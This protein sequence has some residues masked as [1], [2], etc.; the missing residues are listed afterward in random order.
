MLLGRRT[1]EPVRHWIVRR[2]LAVQCSAIMLKKEEEEEEDP[3]HHTTD[4]SS[5]SSRRDSLSVG[6]IGA[7]F[8]GLVVANYLETCPGTGPS[9][10]TTVDDPRRRSDS[11]P[12]TTNR[13]PH[14]RIQYQ[15]FD[16]KPLT[17][18]HTTTTTTPQII[19]TVHLPAAYRVLHAVQLF[20][21][22]V[23]GSVVCRPAT[24]TTTGRPSP[25][26]EQE[27]LENHPDTVVFPR[28]QT[29]AM[30]VARTMTKRQDA[31]ANDDD[32]V[33]DDTSIANT[34]MDGNRNR[35]SN[36]NT[37]RS[38]SINTNTNTQNNDTDADTT[39]D[40]EGSSWL[41]YL[42]VDVEVYNDV[43]RAPFLTLLRHNIPA[44]KFRSSQRV[45][46][47]IR[48]HS[49]SRS[50]SSTHNKEDA[51][52]RTHHL[53][54]STT[55]Q[56]SIVTENTEEHHN[57][58][59]EDARHTTT[60]TSSSSSRQQRQQ[61]QQHHGPFDIIV[62]A[63]GLDF[64]TSSQS[65]TQQ[66]Q[67]TLRN[68]A[69]FASSASSSLSSSL[70]LSVSSVDRSSRSNRNNTTAT[71]TNIVFIGDCGYQYHRKWYDIDWFG[72]K[73]RSCGANTAITEGLHIGRRILHYHQQQQHQQ[74]YQQYQH[75]A[76]AN[77]NN[78]NTSSS[79]C[80]VDKDNTTAHTTERD[81][82]SPSRRTWSATSRWIQN[83]RKTTNWGGAGRVLLCMLVPILFATT[84][85]PWFVATLLA[86]DGGH[87]KRGP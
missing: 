67:Q 8:G 14:A 80:L 10:T 43:A 83:N 18:T 82:P 76:N 1:N 32:D 62:V 60:S 51:R 9:S 41:R 26:P 59:H 19:G 69:V 3:I 79:S 73:R 84:V 39:E 57:R 58:N 75:T 74:Q 35:A 45:V 27:Q 36:S 46:D 31:A 33:D 72:Y 87:T 55:R 17:T 49:S 2:C 28:L 70:S 63:N 52:T 85:Y 78:N 13:C 30:A 6:I 65:K 15:I 50:S 21:D 48:H 77:T 11:P 22:A 44:T 29:A 68:I 34:E 64:N 71:N 81:P 20:D 16:A 25:P 12:P 40:D 7:G 66:L 61:Q 54:R 86:P 23:T 38:R 53:S 5:R 42:D 47:I 4:S 24:T 37:S 56:Y